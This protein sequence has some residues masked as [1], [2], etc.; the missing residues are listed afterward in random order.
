MT[1]I[2][3]IE[4]VWGQGAKPGQFKYHVAIKYNPDSKHKCEGTILSAR[5]VLITA[6]CSDCELSNEYIVAGTI[7]S[8]G[9]NRGVEVRI[10]NVIKHPDNNYDESW[11]QHNLAIIS[12]KEKIPFSDFI[13]PVRLPTTDVKIGVI[14]T[15]TGWIVVKKIL[16]QMMNLVIAIFCFS[17]PQKLLE[18]EYILQ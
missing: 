10:D 16:F 9:S 3:D 6:L 8:D 7:Y 17:S 18:S 1:C 2:R 15:A 4:C 12:T 13:Q 14:A 11:W 5:H